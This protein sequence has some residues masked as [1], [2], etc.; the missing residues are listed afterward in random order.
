VDS[1]QPWVFTNAA[2]LTDPVAN[3]ADLKSRAAAA[4]DQF[5]AGGNAWFFTGSQE[6][7][8]LEADRVLTSLGLVHALDLTGMVADR[9]L[10]PPARPLPEAEV[11]RIEDEPTRIALAELN[12]AAYE[13]PLEW[14]RLAIGHERFWQGPLF[15][16][17]AYVDSQAVAGGFALPIDNALYVAWVATAREYRRRGLAELVMRHSLDAAGPSTG[18]QRTIL[19]A[20]EDGRPVYQRMGYRPICI[21]PI[22]EPSAA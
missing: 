8:G 15:G 14:G 11:R 12:A 5:R 10:P 22:W 6:W 2:V 16:H 3:A 18:L 13:V 17:V 20:T 4:V 19:H 9:L 7:L 1:G 21:F